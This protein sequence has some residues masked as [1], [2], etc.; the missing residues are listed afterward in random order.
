MGGNTDCAQPG[1]ETRTVFNRACVLAALIPLAAV[2]CA[3]SE[4]EV[5]TVATD[6]IVADIP[7]I[8]GS[9]STLPLRMFIM[10]E[11]LDTPCEWRTYPDGTR[12]VLPQQD[13]SLE[14]FSTA[15]R[16]S[17]T[18][19][20]YVAL[21]EGGANLVLTARQPTDQELELGRNAG[22]EFEQS[23]IALDG[24][25]F[26]VN[27]ANPVESLTL[28]QIRSIFSGEI[29]SWADVG[30]HDRPI[31]PYQ[32]NETSG[33]QVLM[34]EMVMDGLAMVD[35]PNMMLP[36]MMAPFDAISRDTDGIGYSVFFYAT[37]IL[38]ND[39]TRLIRI[40]GVEP[41]AD[42]IQ[43]GDYPLV[44]DVYAVLPASA[45]QDDSSRLLYEW[46]KTDRGRDTIQ[47]SGYVAAR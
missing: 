37:H 40:D 2:G 13:T 35:A 36:S 7:V 5:E 12:R 30:G 17:G 22:V 34:E 32:R 3:N 23:A 11:L 39:E 31:Q 8:D 18:H 24:F 43:S 19:G 38:L 6:A 42:T 21:A 25:V 15:V 4:S 20:S 33:S 41:S 16:S 10:C 45:R 14:P 27:A 47:A 26:L 1:C 28:D 44:S 29:T 46:L 9:S